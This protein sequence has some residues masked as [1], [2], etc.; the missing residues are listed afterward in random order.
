MPANFLGRVPQV[1]WLRA[2]ILV[3]IAAAASSSC[4]GPATSPDQPGAASPEMGI[5]QPA[6]VISPALARALAVKVDF[7]VENTSPRDLLTEYGR[8]QPELHLTIDP[9]ISWDDDL[10]GCRLDCSV[11]SIS[12]EAVLRLIVSA[13]DELALVIEPDRVLV[14]TPRRAAEDMLM[15]TYTVGDIISSIKSDPLF[16][17]H[18]DPADDA[19]EA[20]AGDVLDPAGENLVDFVKA[21]VTPAVDPAVARWADDP[22]QGAA[23]TY[24]H[25]MIAVKQTPRGQELVVQA[26]DRLRAVQRWEAAAA[27][28]G[29]PPPMPPTVSPP[30]PEE[31][32]AVRRLLA[33][34]KGINLSGVTLKAALAQLCRETPGLSIVVDPA[35]QSQAADVLARKINFKVSRVPLGAALGVILPQDW[36][37]RVEPGYVHV[38]PGDLPELLEP[39]V[40]SVRALVKALV[41][42]RPA[43]RRAAES[44]DGVLSEAVAGEADV[45]QSL[46]MEIM[47][48]V[49]QDGAGVWDDCGGMASHGLIGGIFFVTQTRDNHAEIARFLGMLA[50]AV[51]KKGTEGVYLDPASVDVSSPAVEALSRRLK[52]KADFTL[53]NGPM[54]E[55]IDALAQKYP[56]LR[57]VTD[58]QLEYTTD[59][60]KRIPLKG[61]LSTEFV[62]LPVNELWREG[63]RCGVWHGYLL[64]TKREWHGQPMP[65]GAYYVKDLLEPAPVPR[66]AEEFAALYPQGCEGDEF[67]Q[68]I[69]KTV[70][71]ASDPRVSNW[72]DE[73]GRATCGLLGPICVVRQTSRGHEGVA[74]LLGLMRKGAK[75]QIDEIENQRR[76]MVPTELDAADLKDTPQDA[77]R[78]RWLAQE[79]HVELAGVDL[80]QA[81]KIINDAVPGVPL[82]IDPDIEAAGVD[83]AAMK[84]NVAAQRMS[85][86]AL[87]DNVLGEN[88]GYRFGEGHVLITS[89]EKLR[90]NLPLATYPVV[91]VF[92]GPYSRRVPAPPGFQPAVDPRTGRMDM[93]ELAQMI[94]TAVNAES[95]RNVAAWDDEGGNAHIDFLDGNLIVTQTR[96]GH[97]KLMQLL[98]D[99][100]RKRFP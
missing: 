48:F 65:M 41:A 15:T 26:L 44:G 6:P 20:E 69:E 86:E 1:R 95:D 19:Q 66:G 72:D 34:E 78:K 80:V 81:V 96:Q 8:T 89:R 99:L 24:K 67:V 73:G 5:P 12:M 18:V 43:V 3:V 29:G 30:E 83:P 21:M 31:M 38:G 47:W 45:L 50:E 76:G 14:T 25:G 46:D 7:I 97:I 61:C 84:V 33:Q 55:A 74:E 68:V 93:Q 17:A 79:A 2:A 94:T 36:Q 57:L 32:A 37:Y 85:M 63:L 16:N 39:Q 62:D 56:D 22:Q 64:V 11:R 27:Q 82:V 9:A 13:S 88:L 75:A 4:V 58:P 92:C 42:L 10:G 59:D 28:P 40:Y 52:E 35:A 71:V 91:R 49:P 70:N 90:E 54:R 77:A 53:G 98:V 23:V 87:L 100:K 60:K 51:A